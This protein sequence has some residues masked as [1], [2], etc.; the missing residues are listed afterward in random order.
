MTITH[1]PTCGNREIRKVRR[2]FAAEFRG[3]PY[4]VPDL[5]FFE[6]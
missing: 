2:N 4:T 1:C 6:R 3:Q 5:E